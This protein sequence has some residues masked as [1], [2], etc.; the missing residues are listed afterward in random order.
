M[1]MN[2]NSSFNLNDRINGRRPSERLPRLLTVPATPSELQKGV[3][4]SSLLISIL[5]VDLRC[6]I[7]LNA[8]CTPVISVQCFHTYCEKCWL[9]T[10]QAQKLCPQCRVITQPGDLRRIYL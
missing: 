3:Q 1:N 6:N 2:A 4:V 7:C 10:L 8:Y 5:I 9:Q